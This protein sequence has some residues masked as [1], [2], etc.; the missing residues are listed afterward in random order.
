MLQNVK[1][2]HGHAKEF[3]RLI[4]ERIKS[5]K[6]E[7]VLK[8]RIGIDLKDYGDFLESFQESTG[9]DNKTLEGLKDIKFS[10]QSDEL[11]KHFSRSNTDSTGSFGLIGLAKN[12]NKIDL[13]CAVYN[14]SVEFK[15]VTL[16]KTKLRSEKEQEFYQDFDFTS[17]DFNKLQENYIKAKAVQ[18]FV[19]EGILTKINYV[20]SIEDAIR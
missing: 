11:I 20:S 13:A 7:T 9:I 4:K 1:V 5:W 14:F 8:R 15:V 16:V 3:E 10:R 18:S 19:S 12:N 2:S 6:K 17:V